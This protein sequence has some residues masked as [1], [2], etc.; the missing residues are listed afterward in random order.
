VTGRDIL[1]APIKRARVHARVEE[2][3]P[4]TVKIKV[5]RQEFDPLSGEWIITGNDEKMKRWRVKSWGNSPGAL[6]RDRWNYTVFYIHFVR[7]L[8]DFMRVLHRL[9][10][11]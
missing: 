10:V 1:G 8:L 7:V 6:G 3:K 9:N 4:F 5:E 11:I 2:R